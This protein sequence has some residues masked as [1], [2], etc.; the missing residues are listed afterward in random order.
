MMQRYLLVTLQDQMSEIMANM[1]AFDDQHRELIFPVDAGDLR[2]GD[3]LL[4]KA[5]EKVPADCKILWGTV[6]VNEATVD[7]GNTPAPVENTPIARSA[8]HILKV[9]SLVDSGAAKAYVTVP[10]TDMH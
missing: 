10:E 4:L 3:L 1:I 7:Q 5:G 9:G 6:W 8:P 2:A